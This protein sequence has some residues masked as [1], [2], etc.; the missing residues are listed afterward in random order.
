MYQGAEA[1]LREREKLIALG[2]LSA[3]LAHELN[4]PAAAARRSAADLSE[5]LEVLQDTVHRFVSSGVE[6][7]GA[8]E[9]VALQKEALERASGAEPLDA[10]EASDREDALVDALDAR[11]ARGWRVGPALAEAGLDEEW[12]DRLRSSAGG[13]FE[14]ALEWVAASLAA[15][16][17]AAD[18]TAGT[19]R[20]SEVVSAMKDYTYMDQAEVQRIDL[21]DGIET[22]LTILGHRLKRG[23]VR[24]VREYD[25]TLPPITAHGSQLNQVWTNLIDNAVDAVDGDGTITIRTS[26][27]G[28]EA[29]VEVADDGPGVPADIADRIFEPFFTTKD[30][31]RGTGLGLDIVSRVVVNHHGR[32]ELS[33]APGPT[34]FCV[35]LPI[36]GADGGR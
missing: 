7:A 5:A 24:L 11:G 6:R 22:T 2:T 15:R 21:H 27:M 8:E 25:R 3:G 19:E 20:I 33:R 18:L 30:V 13:A 34:R 26:R 29:L 35:W 10:L 4:N 17:L 23:R 14:A 1:A 36:D 28:D 31:G 9:L 32:V 12:I 16:G